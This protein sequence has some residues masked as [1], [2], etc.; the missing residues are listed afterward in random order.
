MREGGREWKR[1]EEGER[2]RE[3]ERRREGEGETEEAERAGESG[4]KDQRELTSPSSPFSSC[5]ST[6]STVTLALNLRTLSEN[7]SRLPVEEGEKERSEKGRREAELPTQ[8]V[9]EVGDTLLY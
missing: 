2:G 3:G 6:V 9:K 7:E 4:R 5:A 8:V 1:E